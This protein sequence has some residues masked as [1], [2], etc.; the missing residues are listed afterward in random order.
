MATL[1]L[2]SSKLIQSASCYQHHLETFLILFLENVCKI[3]QIEVRFIA[4]SLRNFDWGLRV[5]PHRSFLEFYFCLTLDVITNYTFTITSQRAAS[6]D[7][8]RRGIAALRILY[9][10][11]SIS[12]YVR[13]LRL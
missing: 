2:L 12:P 13:V 10:T 3:G 7:K 1:R 4:Q 8:G 9:S 6:F 11:L 5:R